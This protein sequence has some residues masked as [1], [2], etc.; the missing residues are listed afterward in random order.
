[1]VRGTLGV[2]KN[3]VRDAAGKPSRVRMA[4]GMA[5]SWVASGGGAVGTAAEGFGTAAFTAAF[6]PIGAVGY[7]ALKAGAMVGKG[8]WAATKAAGRQGQRA[9]N[10]YV[11]GKGLLD[12]KR[13]RISKTAILGM[14][15][16][17][18]AMSTRAAMHYTARSA[19]ERTQRDPANT[20]G[21]TT[22]LHY[23]HR[24]F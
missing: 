5:A 4:G 13:R 23:V 12:A 7:G 24:R 2:V 21:L 1:M 11:P 10:R 3:A 14:T 17:G 9:M 18:L 20:M 15:G 19:N 8:A 22:D 6:A 16:V